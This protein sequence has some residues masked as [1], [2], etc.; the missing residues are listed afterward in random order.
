[1]AREEGFGDENKH[2]EGLRGLEVCARCLPKR[3]GCGAAPEV[4]CGQL[5]AG[6]GWEGAVGWL[7][8]CVVGWWPA[9]TADSAW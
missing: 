6:G 5:R 9:A 8:A 7:D 2:T 4:S 3:G 1:M